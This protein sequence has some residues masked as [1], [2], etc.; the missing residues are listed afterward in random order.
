MIHVCYFYF[1]LNSVSV[2]KK[3]ILSLLWNE[4]KKRHA[5]LKQKD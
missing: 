4:V 5:S 3:L 1:V 2:L